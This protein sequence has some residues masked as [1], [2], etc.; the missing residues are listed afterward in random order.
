MTGYIH[1]V[2]VALDT[3]Q[4][5]ERTVQIEQQDRIKLRS[6]LGVAIADSSVG[7]KSVRVL[8]TPAQADAVGRI[9]HAQPGCSRKPVRWWQLWDWRYWS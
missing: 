5:L 7:K 4:D 6:V 1:N 3:I 2:A 9:L 8:L